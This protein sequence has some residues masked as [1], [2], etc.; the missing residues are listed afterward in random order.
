MTDK[1]GAIHV[2]S[3]VCSNGAGDSDLSVIK[4]SG[5]STI[6][7][8]GITITGDIDA[9]NIRTSGNLTATGDVQV[10]GSFF[11][12]TGN[13]ETFE[14]Y[15]EGASGN[16]GSG[17]AANP[18]ITLGYAG[19]DNGLYSPATDHVGFVTS[20]TERLRITS[21]G[22][23][24]LSG[25]N[26]GT[27]GQ[28]ITSVGG[29]GPPIWTT[30]SGGGGASTTLKTAVYK[31]PGNSST[32]ANSATYVTVPVSTAVGTPDAIY[33]NSSGVVTLGAS[34]VY[35]CMCTVVCS[36]S[37]S[38]Y[39]WAGE[40]NIR[41]DTGAGL[42]E[43][44]SVQGGYIRATDGANETFISINRIIETSDADDTIDFQLRRIND[45]SG[46]A[47]YIQ[48]LSTIQIIKLDGV[49]GPTGA[50][51]PQGPTDIP[52]NSQTSAYTLVADDNGKHINI[53]TGGVT[54]PSG[55][56]SAGNVISIYNDSGSDQTI[57]QGTSVTLREAGTTNTG[58]RTLGNYGLVTIL[59]VGSNEFV[60]SGAGIS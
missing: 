24:G 23:F 16:F 50:T 11:T 20:G 28:V 5:L 39:R 55:V 51:G 53:T 25:A 59:C 21:S 29:D 36:G 35:L 52:Q 41:Q 14:G 1:F 22:A 33:S 27:S 34:G 7:R 48:D 19:Y 56:F 10:S 31:G 4:V 57:T 6:A 58:N 42:T 37:T 49:Q 18:S 30:V 15:V 9:I 3:F 45:V 43:I 38:S 44:G 8:S 47:V 17:T 46:N 54:V 12:E 40:L 2:D 26:Y 32:S 60:I 13:I